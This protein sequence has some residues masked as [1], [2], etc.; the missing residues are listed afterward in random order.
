MPPKCIDHKIEMV[1]K[2]YS[3]F[4]VVFGCPKCAREL[5]EERDGSN[6]HIVRELKRKAREAKK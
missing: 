6:E 4:D 2:F 5:C 3:I 1:P